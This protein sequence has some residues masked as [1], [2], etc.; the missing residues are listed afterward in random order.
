LLNLLSSFSHLF[1]HR[2]IEAPS[3]SIADVGLLRLDLVVGQA[4]VWLL[5]LGAI[6]FGVRWLGKLVA[7]TLGV[8]VL[9][10]ALFSARVHFFDGALDAYADFFVAA[11]DWERLKDYMV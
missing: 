11:T 10:L 5:V 8:P 2:A 6:A 7:F 1:C 3:A 9:L 4:C